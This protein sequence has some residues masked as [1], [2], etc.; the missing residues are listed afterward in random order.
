MPSKK[1][2]FSILLLAAAPAARALEPPT[3][4][5]VE[6]Y[7]RDGSFAW[8]LQNALALGNH[9][10]EPDLVR[11]L[12][13]RL[14]RLRTGDDR[15][16]PRQAGIAELP[17]GR[18]GG[19]SAKGNVKVFALLIDF[20]DYPATQTRDIINER[21]FGNGDIDYPRESLRNYYRRASYN[22]LEIGGATLGWYRPAYTRASMAM[23]SAARESLIREALQAFDAAGHD[24]SVYDNDGNSIIDYFLVIWTGP[25]NGWANFW[26]GYQTSWSSSSTFQLDG[27]KFATAKYSW[28]W[29]S[30]PY[31][32]SPFY[33]YVTIHETGHALGLPDYYDYDASVGPRGGLGRLDM[34]DGNWGDHNAFSKMLLDWITPQIFNYGTSVYALA[35]SGSSQDALILM[36]EFRTTKPFD[37]FYIIQNRHR[38]LNDATYPADGLL[39]W[40]VDARL[41]TS[42]TNFLYD[43]SYA[44]HKLLRLMEADGLEEIERG[45]SANAGD[46]YIAGRSFTPRSSPNSLR[47]DGTDPGVSVLNIGPAGPTM[48]F[49]ADIHYALYPPRNVAVQRLESDFIFFREYIN[50]LSWSADTRNRTEIVGYLIYKKPKSGGDDLYTLVAEVA[51]TALADQTYEHRGLRQD[52]LFVYRIIAVDHNGVESAAVEVSN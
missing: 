42:S 36:P 13:L 32:T 18:K 46:Y 49:T 51:K 16:L 1:I 3:K 31:G 8:R 5:E 17:T 21:L 30:R 52:D 44:V 41:N 39:L 37:E 43:N 40:H 4:S 27:K 47:Y 19:L 20:P 35:A 10:V 15:A 14:E 25:D 2:A 22:M 50:R 38:V 45:Y 29:E 11:S 48:S 23:T 6:Q 12:L 33:P 34:M 28:Q 9:L 24:F 7:I 26:W